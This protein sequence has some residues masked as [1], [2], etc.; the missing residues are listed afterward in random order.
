MVHPESFGG[1]FGMLAIAT[2]CT[3]AIYAVLGF[4]GSVKFGEKVKG[5]ITMNLPLDE[6]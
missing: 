3:C 2:V 5:T 6:G 4:M 1:P